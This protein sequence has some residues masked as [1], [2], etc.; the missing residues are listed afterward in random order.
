MLKKYNV[1]FLFS[2]PL[3]VFPLR[4]E[5]NNM[6]QF[7]LKH[8]FFYTLMACVF[9]LLISRVVSNWRLQFDSRGTHEFVLQDF[10]GGEGNKIK[11]S[12]DGPVIASRSG[13]CT[14]VYARASVPS[15]VNPMQVSN[16]PNAGAHLPGNERQLFFLIVFEGFGP[17]VLV[18]DTTRNSHWNEI[19]IQG[20]IETQQK[21]KTGFSYLLSIIPKS[22]SEYEY[23][24]IE[25]IAFSEET[26]VYNEI[27]EFDLRNG[28]TFCVR[29]NGKT[30]ITVRQLNLAMPKAFIDV[31]SKDIQ[32]KNAVSKLVQWWNSIDE[33]KKM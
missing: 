1:P 4:R 14:F 21:M 22:E 12:I 15:F 33:S 18:D 3:F 13:E 5:K 2:C 8:L 29:Q 6:W 16:A 20:S 23:D 10:M 11:T 31:V 30:G 7:R 24:H 28:K 17:L 27:A 32:D 26:T 9:V 19:T 25:T